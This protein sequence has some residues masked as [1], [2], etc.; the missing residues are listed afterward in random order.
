MVELRF[1]AGMTIKETARVL[2]LSHATVE[3]ELKMARAWLSRDMGR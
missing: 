1:F 3:R 2:E